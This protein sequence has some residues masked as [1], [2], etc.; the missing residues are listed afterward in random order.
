MI[1][2]PPVIII[3][4]NPKEQKFY[5]ELAKFVNQL[6]YQAILVS[7]DQIKQQLTKKLSLEA[8][9]EN[10]SK[11]NPLT[12]PAPPQNFN[13]LGIY[14]NYLSSNEDAQENIYRNLYYGI[15]SSANLKIRRKIRKLIYNQL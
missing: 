13:Q 14:D 5:A 9:I 8:P 15:Y 12:M 10:K 1:N 2:T 6:G 7:Q 11:T 4:N 3:V